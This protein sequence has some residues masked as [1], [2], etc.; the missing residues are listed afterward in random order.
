MI[1]I[2]IRKNNIIGWVVLPLT[3]GALNTIQSDQ[4]LN[5]RE[6]VKF[7]IHELEL[8]EKP[9]FRFLQ[10]C[11]EAFLYNDKSP[12]IRKLIRWIN[13]SFGLLLPQ[14]KNS[15]A[16]EV[17]HGIWYKINSTLPVAVTSKSLNLG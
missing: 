12:Q 8:T 6:M 2:I 9:T 10:T 14:N 7:S 5:K 11:P 16:I 17:C 4:F 15:D 3:T 13:D 1:K